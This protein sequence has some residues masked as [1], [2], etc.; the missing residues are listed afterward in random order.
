LILRSD[1]KRIRVLPDDIESVKDSDVSAMPEGLLDPFSE[2]E[3][4]DLLAFLMDHKDQTA[5]SSSSE[6]R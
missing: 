6:L 3:I 2:S 4:A 5:N 1:G